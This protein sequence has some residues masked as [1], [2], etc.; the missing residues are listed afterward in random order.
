MTKTEQASKKKTDEA[1][2]GE[3][4]KDY[5]ARA[6]KFK[7]QKQ[8]NT[9]TEGCGQSTSDKEYCDGE[10]IDPSFVKVDQSIPSFGCDR[11]KLIDHAAPK[12]GETVVDLG[13]GP[14]KDSLHTA[15]LVGSTG[16][17]IGIDFSD[18]MLELGFYYALII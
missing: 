6:R 3:V 4:H 12:M 10:V 8:N 1:R 14:G 11:G 16:K 13:F 18:E 17:V 7:T 5:S 9:L 15:E 2:M